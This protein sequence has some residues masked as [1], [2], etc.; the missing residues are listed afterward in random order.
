MGV[1]RFHE[2]LA[3]EQVFEL[4]I[5]SLLS[6]VE[7]LRNVHCIIVRAQLLHIY[8]SFFFLNDMHRFD[9]ISIYARC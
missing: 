9:E 5:S 8:I 2:K 6:N 1:E 3:D 7:D 4:L